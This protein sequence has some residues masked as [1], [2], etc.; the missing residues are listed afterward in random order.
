MLCINHIYNTQV[1]NSKGNSLSSLSLLAEDKE[2]S[3]PLHPRTGALA[4]INH[5]IDSSRFK[6]DV[7]VIDEFNSHSGRINYVIDSSRVKCDPYAF[8]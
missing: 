5:A 6:C 7:K 3:F 4:E 8:Y 1:P 2:R